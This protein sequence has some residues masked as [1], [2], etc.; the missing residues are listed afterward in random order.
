MFKE[1]TYMKGEMSMWE[2]SPRISNGW[3][4]NTAVNKIEKFSEMDTFSVNI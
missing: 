2:L 1:Y 4:A 3:E